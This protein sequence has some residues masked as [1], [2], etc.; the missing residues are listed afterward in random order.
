[1]PKTKVELRVGV[2]AKYKF[3]NSFVKKNLEFKIRFKKKLC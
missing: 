3:N 1:M 2:Q